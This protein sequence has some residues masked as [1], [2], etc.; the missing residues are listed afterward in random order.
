MR[1]EPSAATAI[2]WRSA[3]LGVLVTIFL[4]VAPSAGAVTVVSGHPEANELSCA[5]VVGREALRCLHEPHLL[6]T[7]GAGGADTV[8]LSAN[9]A[10]VAVGQKLLKGGVSHFTLYDV[11]KARDI[12]A[13]IGAPGYFSSVNPLDEAAGTYYKNGVAY[14]F[15]FDSKT[16]E[17]ATLSTPGRATGAAAGPYAA[18]AFGN[19]LDGIWNH[20]LNRLTQ[21]APFASTG[22]NSAGIVV[23]QLQNGD[24]GAGFPDGFGGVQLLDLGIHGNAT[25]ITNGNVI[26]GYM[27]QGNLLTPISY[28]LETNGLR[29]YKLPPD[30]RI[31]SLIGMT[32]SGRVAYGN[33]F[34][35]QQAVKRSQSIPV[36]W[37]SPNHPRPLPG[38][39][40]PFTSNARYG[41]VTAITDI[42]MTTGEIRVRGRDIGFI[43]FVSPFAKLELLEAMAEEFLDGELEEE[44]GEALSEIGD[45]LDHFKVKRACRTVRALRS[46]LA[47]ETG[48][49]QLLQGFY[50]GE[51]IARYDDMVGGLEE[52]SWE[53]GCGPVRLPLAH[54][55]P[56]QYPYSGNSSG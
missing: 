5:A 17:K 49:L 25:H 37:R 20:D 40:I 47:A 39:R 4:S 42:G 52:F 33:A 48:R 54:P 24:I 51:E 14:P 28:N 11:G 27:Q 43:R 21:L 36:I 1:T 30:F 6:L 50:A 46:S 53:I 2:G 55:T 16:G 56:S 15:W 34:R 35:N 38:L 45:L 13:R 18:V 7:P 22:I 26:T 9:D 41:A 12:T 3:L 19:G 23:G 32:D 10:G 44:V 8:W 29:E 31:G